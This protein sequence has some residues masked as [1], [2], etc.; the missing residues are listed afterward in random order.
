MQFLHRKPQK[1]QSWAFEPHVRWQEVTEKSEITL[2]PRRVGGWQGATHTGQRRH[3]SAA[4]LGPFWRLKEV[5]EIKAAA[6]T[7]AAKRRPPRLPEEPRR[8]ALTTR[9]RTSQSEFLVTSLLGEGYARSEK[10]NQREMAVW[11][12]KADGADKYETSSR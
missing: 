2:L 7:P 11:F 10:R 8:H 9:R 3:F 12:M 5:Q 1:L 4:E 6:E